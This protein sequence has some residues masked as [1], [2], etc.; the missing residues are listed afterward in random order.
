MWVAAYMRRLDLE[1]IAVVVEA[2][3]DATAGAIIV[4][5][6]TLDGQAKAFHRVTDLD[7]GRRW[8]VLAEGTE[9]EVD[10]TISRQRSF[11]PDLWVIALEDRFGRHMLDLPGLE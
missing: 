10:E 6:S 5:L 3:G 1:A 11:D 7:L 4:R 8:D 2:R 9:A